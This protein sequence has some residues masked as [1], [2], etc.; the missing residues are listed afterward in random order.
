MEKMIKFLKQ[1][2]VIKYSLF[3]DLTNPVAPYIISCLL[4]DEDTG[5]IML[6]MRQMS[7]SYNYLKSFVFKGE[8][9][10]SNICGICSYWDR[11]NTEKDIIHHVLSSHEF[12]VNTLHPLFCG[13]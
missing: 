12:N 5:K 4:H 10:T 3:K 11:K 13:T 1:S 8:D 9:N 6:R 7:Y 2:K